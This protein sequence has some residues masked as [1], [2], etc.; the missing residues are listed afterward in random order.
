M[1]YYKVNPQSDQ[2]Q[3]HK[4]K[5]FLIANELKTVKELLRLNI[6][7]P[8]FVEKHFTVLEVSKNKTYFSFGARFKLS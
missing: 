8:M 3:V 6:T 4:S 7:N 5:S 2:I 1:K